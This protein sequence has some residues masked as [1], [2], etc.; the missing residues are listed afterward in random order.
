MPFI[1]NMPK[2]SL[3]AGT[4][5]ANAI[6]SLFVDAPMAQ[7]QLQLN[8][9]KAQSLINSQLLAGQKS[10]EEARGLRLTNNLR[11]GTANIDE[12]LAKA[13]PNYKNLSA[14]E[15]AGLRSFTMLG[16][17]MRN[18][19]QALNDYQEFYDREAIKNDPR[20][21]GK[22]NQ[23]YFAVKGSD[24]RMKLG[25]ND[26]ITSLFGGFGQVG[27]DGNY[28]Q[29]PAGGGA[30]IQ[31]AANV[32]VRGEVLP[33]SQI[34]YQN[35]SNKKGQS[36]RRMAIGLDNLQ[37]AMNNLLS[38]DG[39][40]FKN[41]KNTYGDAIQSTWVGRK[42]GDILGTDNATYRDD[43]NKAVSGMIGDYMNAA[44]LSASQGSSDAEGER[45]KASIADP[46]S[47]YDSNMAAIQAYRQK[48]NIPSSG[49]PATSVL[50]K[51]P[52]NGD[53]LNGYKY[54]GGSDGRKNEAGNP[55]N[56]VFVGENTNTKPLNQQ[57]PGGVKSKSKAP[58]GISQTDWDL[59]TDEEKAQWKS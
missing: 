49:H 7:E 43:I 29:L 4:G 56:W 31:P 16:K 58:A 35:P 57:S 9:A 54:V 55:A 38:D 19:S 21:A 2:N 48:F 46:S 33:G 51:R 23:S 47:S 42:M 20:L 28:K 12:Y 39:I 1:S 40:V 34:T 18:H 8:A 45:L 10:E 37:M 44:N 41:D 26:S 32:N 22:I 25:E 52:K 6:K 5:M 36:L 27:V 30:Q 11:D 59:L 14:P 50:T 13:N 17:D 24:P 3:D 15:Q 53:I